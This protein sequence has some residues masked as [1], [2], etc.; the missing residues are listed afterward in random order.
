MHERE[1]A[2]SNLAGGEVCEVCVKNVETC[3]FDGKGA[4]LAGGGAE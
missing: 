3:D 2:V 4:A 1:V